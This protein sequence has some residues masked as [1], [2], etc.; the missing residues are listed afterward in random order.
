MSASITRR[1]AVGAF[2]L[3]AVVITPYSAAADPI[4]LTVNSGPSLQQTKNRPCVIGDPSC[5]NPSTLSYTLLR[6]QMKAATVDSPTYTVNQIRSLVGDTF[7]VGVDLNQA[8][9]HDG[10]A[11]DLLSFS[12]AVNGSI[13]FRTASPSVLT[14]IN[15]G[16]GYS[17]ASIVGFSLAG[18]PGDAKL[19]FTTKFSG[20]TAGREQYFLRA[21]AAST[22]IR[23]SVSPTPEPLSLLLVGSG[24]I[25]TAAWQRRRQ[26]NSR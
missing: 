17:D 7:F 26:R 13:M 3:A 2:L 5:H 4:L 8:R 15:P 18:L 23:S 25:G 1:T 6:P 16:N 9:G 12:L 21:A 22:P 10:G 24:L 14:P 11:Y 19:V 20:G